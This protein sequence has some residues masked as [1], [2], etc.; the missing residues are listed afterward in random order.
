MNS[1]IN[2]RKILAA[3]AEICGGSDAGGHYHCID[4]WTKWVLTSKEEL[5]GGINC[6]TG[7]DHETVSSQHRVAMK[8]NTG[9]GQVLF[10][11]GHTEME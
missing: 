7:G 4:D 10:L 6:Q 9:A 1:R 5:T 2:S 11:A 8:K 3:L